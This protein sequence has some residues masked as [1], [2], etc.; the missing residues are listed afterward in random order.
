LR[1]SDQINLAVHPD[2]EVGTR[3]RAAQ[4][5]RWPAAIAL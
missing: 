2:D 4:P 3:A 1:A 5:P